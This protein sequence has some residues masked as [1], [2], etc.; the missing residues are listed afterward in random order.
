MS[1]G[2]LEPTL[3]L[4]VN[5]RAKNDAAIERQDLYQ[6]VRAVLVTILAFWRAQGGPKLVQFSVRYLRF[7]QECFDFGEGIEH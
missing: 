4:S 7:A 1:N 5:G 6:H 3:S 2:L